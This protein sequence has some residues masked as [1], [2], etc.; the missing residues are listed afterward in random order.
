LISAATCGGTNFSQA[1]SRAL[2]FRSSSR[3]KTLP[4]FSLGQNDSHPHSKFAEYRHDSE[5]IL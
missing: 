4:T 5:E 2:I 1:E 3:E